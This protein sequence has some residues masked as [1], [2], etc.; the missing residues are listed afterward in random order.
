MIKPMKRLLK[1]ARGQFTLALQREPSPPL[2][3]ARK[4]EVLKALA[5]LLLEA[6]G[7]ET[8]EDQS[9]EEESDESKDHA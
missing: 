8:R 4:E 7:A 9:E 1:T 3:E 6:L 5:D 2:N